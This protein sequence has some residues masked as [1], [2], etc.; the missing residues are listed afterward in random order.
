MLYA[1]LAGRMGYAV[2]D[3]AYRSAQVRVG[4]FC[5]FAGEPDARVAAWQPENTR[6][7][8]ILIPRTPDWRPLIEQ[9]Y[10]QARLTER[11]AFAK[12][13]AFQRAKLSV[14]AARVPDGYALRR[15]DGALFR[16]AGHGRQPQGSTKS[17]PRGTM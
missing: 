3:G 1:Y 14:L 6:P 9:C 11:Y 8:T 13:N 2:A 16:Q 7:Y 17:W 12:K 5:F 15:M 10:P 4:D